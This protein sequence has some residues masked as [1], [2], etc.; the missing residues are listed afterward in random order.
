MKKIN[1]IIAYTLLGVV[2]LG[3]VLTA[4]LKKDFSPN[5]DLSKGE[6][7][8]EEKGSGAKYDGLTSKDEKVYNEFVK[9]YND[10]FKLTILYSIFSGKI[11]RKQEIENYGKDAPTFS[12]GF[13]ITINF[14]EAQTLKSNGKVYY[15]STNS[16]TPTLYKKAFFVVEDGKGLTTKYIYFRSETNRYYRLTTL[17]NFDELYK[18]INQMD[19]FKTAE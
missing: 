13:V 2:L 12:N 11:S 4:I 15:E 3:L 1:Q 9:T 10:S 18:N 17:A 7:F 14:G 16:D 8:I 5:I 19:M 6:L